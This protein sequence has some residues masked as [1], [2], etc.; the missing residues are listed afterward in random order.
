MDIG[1]EYTHTLS[2]EGVSDYNRIIREMEAQSKEK[3]VTFL[4]NT[5]D[6]EYREDTENRVLLDAVKRYISPEVVWKDSFNWKDETYYQYCDRI[7][8]QKYLL[9]CVFTSNGELREF[10]TEGLGEN[11]LKY[12]VFT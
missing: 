8:W 1:G 4:A 3:D 2:R 7:Q 12:N 6:P 11:A 9:R 5:E 10:D